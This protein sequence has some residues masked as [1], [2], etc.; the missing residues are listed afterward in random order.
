MSDKPLQID[1]FIG[2]TTDRKPKVGDGSHVL[3]K[4][5]PKYP[6][7]AGM[8]DFE[9][10][11]PDGKTCSDCKY[12][13]TVAV[14]TPKPTGLKLIKAEPACAMYAKRTGKPR[15][16]KLAGRLACKCFAE[17]NVVRSWIIKGD[18]RGP[19]SW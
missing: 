3:L 9:G 10:T 13:G 11:G 5:R 14:E 1:M 6:P 16:A 8:A 17:S 12:Y 7:V 2:E 15:Q 18:G 19:F 4:E